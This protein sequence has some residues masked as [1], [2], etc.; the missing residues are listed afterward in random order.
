MNPERV[1]GLLAGI[2]LA[3]TNRTMLNPHLAELLLWV[4]A[5]VDHRSALVKTMQLTDDA[6]RRS[7]QQLMGRGIRI[8]GTVVHSRMRLIEERKHPDRPGMQLL[9]TPEAQQLIA[10]TFA[11]PST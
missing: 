10:S 3:Q 2:R 7:L 8:R 4:A 9:L 5:G 1:A 6:V 11:P